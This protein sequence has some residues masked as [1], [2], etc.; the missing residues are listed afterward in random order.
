[1]GQQMNSN[2]GW[3]MRNVISSAINHAIEDMT[4]IP[5]DSRLF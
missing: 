1:M 3:E 2:H 4:F 5:K